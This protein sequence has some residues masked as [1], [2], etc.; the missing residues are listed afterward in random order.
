M[1][2]I[3]LIIPALMAV[4]GCA[5][6]S[7]LAARSPDG[8]SFHLVLIR[9]REN[10]GWAFRLPI[11][12]DGKVV[13]KIKNGDYVDLALK[14]GTY[15]IST[16]GGAVVG[17]FF[18]ASATITGAAGERKIFSY[19]RKYHEAYN[20]YPAGSGG[21]YYNVSSDFL[22]ADD[23]KWREIAPEDFEKHYADAGRK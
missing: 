10:P 22:V 5:N 20:D 2:L 21:V 7:R 1:K 12:L 4:C 16:G 15:A 9:P 8:H 14:P 17:H 3:Y 19:T 13:A 11:L 23:A 18:Q 6:S